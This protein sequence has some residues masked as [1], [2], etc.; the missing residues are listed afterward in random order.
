MGSS[1]TGV[2][3]ASFTTL[4]TG[5]ILD[6]ADL[7]ADRGYDSFWAAETTGPEAPTLLAGVGARAPLDLGTGIIPLQLR[8]PTVTAMAMATLQSLVPDRDIYCGLGISSPVVTERWHGVDYGDRPLAR[9]REYIAAVRECLTGEAVSFDGDYW[10]F[11]RFRLGVR[12]GGRRP[13]I[14][15]GALNPG[16]LRLAGEVADG[17]LLN[18]LPADHVPW[19]IDRVREGG[20]AREGDR[21]RIHA[22]VHVGVCDPEEAVTPARRDLFSYAVVDGL[23]TQLRARR[24]RRRGRRDPRAPRRSGPGTA[25]WPPCRTAWSLPSTDSAMPPPFRTAS[26]S[27]GPPGSTT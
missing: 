8:P 15:L 14:V 6:M 26:A 3:C 16:M 10:S 4:G 13:K 1:T 22:Y 23:R 17:V 2:T 19:S 5:G 11:S 18:Y 25:R 20:R 24:I 27:T 21:A 7:A 9:V 12:L